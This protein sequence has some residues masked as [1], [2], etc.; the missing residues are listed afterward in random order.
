MSKAVEFYPVVVP[1]SGAGAEVDPVR[2]RVA[3]AGRV[4]PGDVVVG[5]ASA[6]R[7]AGG[8]PLVRMG[9]Q[10]PYTAQPRPFAAGCRCACCASLPSP[11]GP[12]EVVLMAAG[13]AGNPWSE[14]ES[15][16]ATEPVL[17]VPAGG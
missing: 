1:R 11:Y 8:R 7:A 10:E 14:C 15:Y 4:A 12:L 6:V 13:A 17:V 5:Y 3:A 16:A 9:Y 2:V